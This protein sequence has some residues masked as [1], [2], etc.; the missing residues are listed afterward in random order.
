M[1]VVPS[2]PGIYIQELPSNTHTI[3]AAPTSV[4]VFVGYVHPFKTPQSNFGQALEIFSFSDY[5]RLFGG[6]YQSA[7]I[8]ANVS[9]AV[10]EFF[11]NGGTDAFV[12]GLQPTNYYG[13]ASSSSPAFI[14][15][16]SESAGIGFVPLQPLDVPGT[17]MSITIKNVQPDATG[18]LTIADISI[19]YGS[20]VE[21]YSATSLD[22]ASAS[23]IAKAGE[24]NGKSKLVTVQAGQ[25]ILGGSAN[26]PAVYPSLTYSETQSLPSAIPQAAGTLSQSGIGF[27]PLVPT[28]QS[29]SI[30]IGNVQQDSSGKLTIADLTM[31][32]GTAT[33]TYPA[34]PLANIATAINGVSKLVTV[35]PGTAYPTAYPSAAYSE[36]KVIT[37]Q[38]AGAT[39]I[40]DNAV[41]GVGIE[42]TAL[43]STKPQT[44]TVTISNIQKDASNNLTI[45]DM[46][47]S[48]TGATAETYLATSLN[49]S[50]PKFLATM[51]NGVSKIVTVAPD[52]VYP[53]A[54][55]STPAY[56]DT[57]TLDG[58]P[59]G[60]ELILAEGLAGIE[61]TALEPTDA[62]Q[63]TVTI[64]NVQADATTGNLTTADIAITYG[65]QT[66][67]YRKISLNSANQNPNFLETRINGVSALV[68]VSPNPVYP[69]AFAA[70]SYT[71]VQILS[72]PAPAGAVSVFSASDFTNVFQEDSSLDKVAIFNLLLTPGIVNNEVLS[73]ALSFAERKLAFYIMDPPPEDVADPPTDWIGDFLQNSTG[74]G[75]T[76]G[77]V[78]PQ[79]PNGGLYFPYLLSTNPVTGLPTTV[80]GLPFTLPPSGYVAGIFAATDSSRGVW[81]APAGLATTLTDTTGV[82]PGGVMTD[83]RQGVLN[84]IGVNC[85]R[86]FPS[87]GTVVFGARTLVSANPAF[88]QWTYVPV[89]RMALFLE[90]TLKAN[91]PWVVFRPMTIRF[92][93]PSGSRFRASCCRYSTRGRSRDRR[94][95]MRFR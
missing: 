39:A 2:Y 89:R 25:G 93:W 30:T 50:D 66:E 33:E 45:A 70:K 22:P 38:P 3:A 31:V 54:Y 36:T 69:P 87:T 82:V 53:P 7:V 32:Q 55:P 76:D 24:I 12:V 16:R 35:G 19:S 40:L 73:E 41:A 6:F 18:K 17:A 80:T 44:L 95:A 5:E 90:Q 59:A 56:T 72:T 28:D 37:G 27:T 71:E 74:T 14:L 29:L 15:N 48:Q 26:F 61:F 34:T 52:I 65:G 46:A 9:Y 21:S 77:N 57:G 47:V 67:V 84:L 62:V 86:N 42:F 43:A 91:L 85:L 1:P 8:D 92:G 49:S 75:D 81:K 79:S 13:S 10:N 23:Y 63:M 11:Q 64:N 83:T 68:T 51:I 58:D 60:T 78:A 94:P 4:T 20:I 88:Q